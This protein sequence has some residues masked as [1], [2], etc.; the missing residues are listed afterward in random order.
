M[1]PSTN[2]RVAQHTSEEIYSRIA[3]ETR[4]RITYFSTRSPREISRQ[5]INQCRDQSRLAP[6]AQRFAGEREYREGEGRA[7]PYAALATANQ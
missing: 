4:D 3:K 1:L 2:Q 5:A 6:A 7:D